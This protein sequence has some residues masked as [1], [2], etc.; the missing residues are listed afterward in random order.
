MRTSYRMAIAVALVGMLSLPQGA[1]AS[2]PDTN[3][4]ISFSGGPL[5]RLDIF[6]TQPDG[7]DRV[8]LTDGRFD[9]SPAW[10]PDGAQVAFVRFRNA[11]SSIFLVDADGTGLRR[12]TPKGRFIYDYSPGWAPDGLQIVF[13]RSDADEIV[14]LWTIGTDGTG[15]V[16]LTGD[17]NVSDYSPVWSPD[18]SQLAFVRCDGFQCQLMVGDADA[19]DAIPLTEGFFDEGPD[20]SP[21][22]LKIVFQR[23]ES[24]A[25]PAD[26]YLV[27]A[28]GAGLTQITDG[29]Q[30][31]EWPAFS[32][33]GSLIVFGRSAKLSTPHDLYTIAPDGTDPQRLTRTKKLEESWPSWQPVPPSASRG[34]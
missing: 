27:D 11:G 19:A 31:D 13:S 4:R 29:T 24:F 17:P 5:D 30:W 21:D 10:S 9:G 6:T 22:G 16:Q 8:Q 34:L 33:D 28:D 32:P 20:W 14:G 25:T 18:G 26:L 7:S 2:F 12:L 3:G 1:L 23:A 15:L